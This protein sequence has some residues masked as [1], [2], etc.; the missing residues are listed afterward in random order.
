M[1]DCLCTCT[2]LTGWW[3][4]CYVQVPSPGVFNAG[5]HLHMLQWVDCVLL[6]LT[7]FGWNLYSD[8][9]CSLQVPVGCMKIAGNETHKQH[10]LQILQIPL[11]ILIIAQSSGKQW[12]YCIT[13]CTY[14]LALYDN[15]I[16]IPI[17]WNI[18]H[19]HCMH[20]QIWLPLLI[21]LQKQLIP[22]SPRHEW[23]DFHGQAGIKLEGVVDH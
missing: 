4:Q 5:L 18:H 6:A 17:Y 10:S 22:I 15:S 12:H 1:F 19:V 2:C 7:G 16:T 9:T 20:C 13:Y 11:D 23:K 3:G 21:H 8:F 14:C